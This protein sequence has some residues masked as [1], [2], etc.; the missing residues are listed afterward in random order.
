MPGTVGIRRVRELQVRCRSKRGCGECGG[1]QQRNQDCDHW[2]GLKHLDKRCGG[3][4]KQ[5][6]GYRK[7]LRLSM[8]PLKPLLTFTS[9]LV[10]RLVQPV[11]SSTGVSAVVST[12]LADSPVPL[13]VRLNVVDPE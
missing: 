13:L 9:T 5:T 11:V 12:R 3:A 4:A 6:S 7:Y 2:S 8:A 10:E 1:A